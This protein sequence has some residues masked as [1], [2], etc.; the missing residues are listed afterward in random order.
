MQIQYTLIQSEGYMWY[1]GERPE[2]FC[3]DEDVDNVKIQH[4]GHEMTSSMS[5]ENFALIKDLLHEYF[6]ARLIQMNLCPGRWGER[7][8]LLHNHLGAE[9]FPL[10][11]ASDCSEI[12]SVYERW[13][14][15]EPHQKRA[16]FRGLLNPEH[17]EE[18]LFLLRKVIG[19]GT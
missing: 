19:K 14:N 8:T 5:K 2:S 10:F 17:A 3:I 12:H 18:R 4:I 16:L 6:C 11:L 9:T 1:L 15:F 7:R 13:N